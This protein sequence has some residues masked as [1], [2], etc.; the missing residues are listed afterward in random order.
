MLP[1]QMVFRLSNGLWLHDV[2]KIMNAG[3]INDCSK[4][5]C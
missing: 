2:V 3:G 1:W 4:E 5:C